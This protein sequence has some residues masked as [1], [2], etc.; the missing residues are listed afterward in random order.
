MISP[1]TRQA[2]SL[3]QSLFGNSVNQTKNY[4]RR[5]FDN[6]VP[7]MKDS[8]KSKMSGIKNS[9]NAPQ[10]DITAKE[11]KQLDDLIKSH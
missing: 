11:K 6:S 7:K 2:Q 4:S 8:V 9:N 10:E 1:A 3:A 5:L